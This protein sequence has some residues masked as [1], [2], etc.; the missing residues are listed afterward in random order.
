MPHA[1]VEKVSLW[2]VACDNHFDQCKMSKPSGSGY[3]TVYNTQVRAR[4]TTHIG[5]VCA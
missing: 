4:F 5:V 1:V 2:A 3:K